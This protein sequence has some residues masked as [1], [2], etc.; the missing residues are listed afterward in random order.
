LS[1]YD[2]VATKSAEYDL[3]WL[4]LNSLGYALLE[5]R[6]PK[7]AIAIFERNSRVF[8]KSSDGFDGL[9]DAYLAA[10]DTARAI[11]GYRKALELDPSNVHSNRMLRSLE[12]RLR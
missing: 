8:P 4:Q 12:Q 7:D 5:E 6:R 10:R 3:G 2:S 9:G 11:A 1:Y